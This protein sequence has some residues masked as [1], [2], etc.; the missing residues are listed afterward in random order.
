VASLLIVED[1]PST[2]R[3]LELAFDI[4]GHEIEV[5]QSGAEA[6]A[7]LRGPAADV[8]LL[9]VMLPEIDGLEVLRKLRSTPGWESTRVVLVSALDGDEDVWQGWTS[10]TDSYV[11]KPFDLGELRGI[12][13]RLLGGGA[14]T[15]SRATATARR[16]AAA[17]S[18]LDEA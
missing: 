4:E 10:G 2:A 8:V 1:D 13:A 14:A 3:L 9:D 15:P 11:T 18:A 17:G 6:A 7:R 16:R 12:V 5:L